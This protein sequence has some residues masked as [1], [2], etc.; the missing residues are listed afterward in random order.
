MRDNPRPISIP[1]SI[2]GAVNNVAT[3]VPVA[4]RP[5]CVSSTTNLK[6]SMGLINFITAPIT[7]APKMALGNSSRR[8]TRGRT[9]R[10]KTPVIAPAQGV[11]AP[12]ILFNELRPNEPPTGNEFEIAD[13]RLAIP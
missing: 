11:S 9:A 3:S 8:K 4:I 2:L 7:V 6:N 12:A 5:C 1:R 13:A 10:T